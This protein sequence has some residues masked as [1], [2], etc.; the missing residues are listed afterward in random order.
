MPRFHCCKTPQRLVCSG[1]PDF[2]NSGEKLL[3]SYVTSFTG[4]LWWGSYT[5]WKRTVFAQVLDDFYLWFNSS[6]SACWICCSSSKHVYHLL[7]T[8]LTTLSF[9]SVITIMETI[10]GMPSPSCLYHSSLGSTMQALS[11]VRW[12]DRGLWAVGATRRLGS[13]LWMSSRTSSK[14]CE[15]SP[16]FV[17]AHPSRASVYH[18]WGDSY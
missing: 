11:P 1:W 14:C 2:T 9:R 6:F 5:D 8:S 3:S 10:L 18:R 12:A 16:L 4:W 13:M 17:T 15:Q 7:Y